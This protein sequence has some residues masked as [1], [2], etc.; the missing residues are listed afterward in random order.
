MRYTDDVSMRQS[1]YQHWTSTLPYCSYLDQ[2][3]NDVL[4][5]LTIYLAE[6]SGCESS[7]HLLWQD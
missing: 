2:A 1:H 6:P 7:Q 3:C 4:P 5:L